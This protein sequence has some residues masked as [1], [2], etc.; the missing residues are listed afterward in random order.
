VRG[1]ALTPTLVSADFSET[2]RSFSFEAFLFCRRVLGLIGFTCIARKLTHRPD[3]PNMLQTLR[4]TSCSFECSTKDWRF[5]L[6]R[7]ALLI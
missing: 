1:A 6:Y 2:T 5:A 7:L 4:E 3:Q